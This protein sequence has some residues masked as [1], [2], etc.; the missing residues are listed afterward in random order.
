[1]LYRSEAFQYL[2]WKEAVGSLDRAHEMKSMLHYCNRTQHLRE[3]RIA[4]NNSPGPKPFLHEA[5]GY[6]HSVGPL[7][8]E[9]FAIH[10]FLPL[11]AFCRKHDCTHCVNGSL[12][13]SLYRFWFVRYCHG[14]GQCTWNISF[15]PL[16]KLPLPWRHR[17]IQHD[18]E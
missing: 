2:L 1:M 4:T 17:L 14:V 13:L 3:P 10:N 15:A 8:T 9:T 6:S 12:A 5:Q 11:F 7:I 18:E 16:H